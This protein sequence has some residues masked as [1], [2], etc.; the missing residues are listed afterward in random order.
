MNPLLLTSTLTLILLCTSTARAQLD[1]LG[2]DDLTR[3]V[4]KLEA[5]VDRL[6]SRL[7]QMAQSSPG[8]QTA[9][10]PSPLVASSARMQQGGSP[11]EVQNARIVAEL[12]SP[13]ELEFSESPLSDVTEYLSALHGIPVRI[14]PRMIEAGFDAYFPVTIIETGVSLRSALDLVLRPHDL[15]YIIQDEVLKITTAEIAEQHRETHVYDVRQI[16]DIPVDELARV[17]R[18]T[19]R[20]DSWRVES[21]PAM[22]GGGG[23]GGRPSAPRENGS[24]TAAIEPLGQFLVVTQSQRGHRE[25]EQLL[26]K[27]SVMRSARTSERTMDGVGPESAEQAGIGG[28]PKSTPTVDLKLQELD[29]SRGSDTG[30]F[31]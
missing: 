23:L 29:L 14:D 8:D 20:P 1:I 30:Q 28:P 22:P 16:G 7:D 27:L 12:D 2:E 6:R 19:I 15:D 24:R 18:S 21:A 17:I 5:E 25:I 11:S 26:A 10:S 9:S 4:E 13:T 3:R 31:D